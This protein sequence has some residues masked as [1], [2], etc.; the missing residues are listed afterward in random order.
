[1][2]FYVSIY[3]TDNEGDCEMSDLLITAPHSV[4]KEMLQMY[5]EQFTEHFVLQKHGNNSWILKLSNQS[6]VIN[7]LNKPILS[8]FVSYSHTEEQ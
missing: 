3:N 2:I 8:F 6:G 5:F 7:K 4:D 1:M